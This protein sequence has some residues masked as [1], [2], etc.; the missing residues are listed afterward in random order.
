MN[1]KI[2]KITVYLTKGEGYTIISNTIFYFSIRED[3]L[4][5]SCEIFNKRTGSQGTLIFY[6]CLIDKFNIVDF[7][8][9]F[10]L[11]FAEEYHYLL[12]HFIDERIKILL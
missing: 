6:H 4:F 12:D 9:N 1:L 2:G 5:C 7:Y 3:T 8:N 10:K 11:V